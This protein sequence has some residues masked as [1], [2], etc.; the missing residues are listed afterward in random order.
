[1]GEV[2]A[3]RDLVLEKRSKM[4]LPHV[5]IPALTG[6]ATGMF[7]QF[8]IDS[9]YF[10]SPWSLGTYLDSLWN[11]HVALIAVM[12]SG[13]LA[14]FS[15]WSYKG[16]ENSLFEF[17]IGSLAMVVLAMLISTMRGCGLF[18]LL[19]VWFFSSASW[20]RY[21]MPPFRLGVWWGMGLV[22]GSLSGVLALDLRT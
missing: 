18:L 3:S 17:I 19:L 6:G 22:I 16:K 10:P 5:V 21:E 7:V 11:V 13:S 9:G 15:Y 4:S 1:M 12:I 20:G 8:L 14:I 2:E